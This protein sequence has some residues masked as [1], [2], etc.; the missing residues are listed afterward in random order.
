[1]SKINR[2]SG[3]VINLIAYLNTRHIRCIW[4]L[5][6]VEL[7]KSH[8]IKCSFSFLTHFCDGFLPCLPCLQEKGRLNKAE[9]GLI[10]AVPQQ[11]KSPKS[12]SLLAL[13]ASRTFSLTNSYKERKGSRD[14][15]NL[16]HKRHDNMNNESTKYLLFYLEGIL[17][18]F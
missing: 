3:S 14:Q 4:R 6:R 7:I 5:N 18:V 10:C 1:M 9:K 12:T 2:N 16:L 8:S 13:F 11:H 17:L 15:T